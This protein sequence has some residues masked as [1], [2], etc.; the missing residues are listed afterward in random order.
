MSSV[1][2]DLIDQEAVIATLKDAVTA[3]KD[4]TNI[5]QGMTHSWL[6]TGPPGSGR[7]NA[8][9]AFAAAL[10]CEKGGCGVCINCLTVK[11]GS[12]TDI[13][14]IRTE[15]LSIKVDEVRE[16][17]TRTSWSPSVGNYRVVVIEDAD[18]L[19]ESAANALLKVIEEPGARTV[20][21]LCAPTL[22]DVLPTIRSRCRH[23]TLRT[24]SIEAITKLLIDRDGIEPNM[25]KFAAS[26]AQG[27]IGRAKFLATNE[28]A[29]KTKNLILDIA[30]NISNLNSAFQAASTLIEMA[31]SD[32]IRESE[33]RNESE[34][35]KLK[36]SIA[37]N[38][39]KL[40]SGG[41]KFVKELEAIQRNR[42]LSSTLRL[43]DLYLLEISDSI[44]DSKNL[45]ICCKNIEIP[46]HVCDSRFYK[47]KILEFKN[48][49][50]KIRNKLKFNPS[51]NLLIESLFVQLIHLN[52]VLQKVKNM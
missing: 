10:L 24:P 40:I 36:N 50:L 6:F 43:L 37:T 16:L 21:L 31:K 38:G 14:L 19:T 15:G 28:D 27:H 25:A 41:N 46:D 30:T 3:S 33:I 13:E 7:S 2:D 32:V 11:N 9:V 42:N 22:T 26:A 23:L 20:W 8:A 4:L 12:H 5:T 48:E 35:L 17:I 18:R 49:I 47:I 45:I 1:F 44:Y 29:R 34:M 51:I 52:P 39:G